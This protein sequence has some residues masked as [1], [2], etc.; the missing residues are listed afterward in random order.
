MY[1][2]VFLLGRTSFK[3]NIYDACIVE[4]NVFGTFADGL[5]IIC[6]AWL[7]TG[8]WMLTT[9]YEGGGEP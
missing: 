7:L 4:T 3:K 2:C 9:G 1:T 6:R 8:W 5:G